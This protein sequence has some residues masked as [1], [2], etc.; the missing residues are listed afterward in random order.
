LEP[1]KVVKRDGIEENFN[2]NKIFNAVKSSASN[3]VS[4][5]DAHNIATDITNRVS[6][7]I[8]HDTSV[9]AIQ[10]VVEKTLM[11]SKYKDIAK[12]Y[13]A[14][15][16]ER[17]RIRE[18]KSNLIK[19]VEGLFNTDNEDV[20]LEN[21]NKDSNR[22]PT[23]RDL[24]A[25]VISK[26]YALNHLLPHRVTEAHKDGLLHYHD[27]D[28]SPMFGS[29][30]CQLMGYEKMLKN[31]FKMGNVDI[32]QPR[33]IRTACTV[34][35]QIMAQVASES[36]GGLTANNIDIVMAPYVTKSYNRYLEEAKKFNITD[37]EGYSKAKTE[38][39][40]YD[41]FQTVE[42]QINT[43]STTNGQSPFSTLSF[44]LGTSWE[45][46][47]IQ[48]VI[49]EVRIEGIGKRKKTPTFPKLCFVLKDGLNLKQGDP[50]YDIKQLAMKCQ[51]KRIYPDLLNYDQVVKVTGSFKAPMGRR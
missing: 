13:I 30:N 21:S 51:R 18:E 2:I 47:I 6:S 11:S 41:A 8:V 37:A 50:N 27:L 16:A 17:N 35:T 23:Q 29:Y 39:E 14:Y 40:V 36:Y 49:L 46:R 19:E 5:Y 1:I 15:R 42:Y 12:H 9:E 33:S 10:D 20:I 32:E 38:K 3:C 25:G 24:L 43:L 7:K 28:Y 26:D 44:G 34:L 48:Q 31:G 4:D 45:E 22:I